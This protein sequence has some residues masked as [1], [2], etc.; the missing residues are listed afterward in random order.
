MKGLHKN[1]YVLSFLVHGVSVFVTDIH[2]DV[3]KELG[4]L[5][6][7]DQGM[8][9][10]YFERSAYETALDMGVNFYSDED[11][12]S[13]YQK[14]LKEHC[15]QFDS[16]YETQIK[17][18]DALT[19]DVVQRLFD[20]TT[21]L[22]KDYSLM[23]IEHTDKAFSLQENSPIIK[24]NL[25]AAAVFKDWIR[26]YMNIVLFESDGY[27]SEA[28]KILGK[29]FVLQP[30]I[31]HDCTQ[32][33]I[34]SLFDGKIPNKEEISKRQ[35]AFVINYDRNHLFQGD[36]ALEIINEFKEIASATNSLSLAKL[37]VWGK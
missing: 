5:F 24:K 11:A 9:K 14:S 18:R 16:F 7:I 34:L 3:Y 23:N 2:V 30:Y 19:K 4:V 12:F 37:P 21:K 10:Q 26:S 33:E 8:F 13:E 22:C 17:D 35:Q 1:D 15:G 29:Q 20:F 31:L 6:L 27:V 28:F 25:A 36:D 32:Q